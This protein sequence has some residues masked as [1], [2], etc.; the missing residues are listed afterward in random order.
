MKKKIVLIILSSIFFFCNTFAQKLIEFGEID[1]SKKDKPISVSNEDLKSDLI[2]IISGFP[3][4]GDKNKL[5]LKNGESEIKHVSKEGES[6]EQIVFKIPIA[7]LNQP[8]VANLKLPFIFNSKQIGSI[9]FN[10]KTQDQVNPVVVVQPAV[11]L[12]VAVVDVPVVVITPEPDLSTAYQKAFKDKTGK[13]FSSGKII[14]D[15]KLN[16]TRER[17]VIH[18][19]LDAEGTFYKSSLPTT[20][21]EDNI[22]IFHVFY[23]EGEKPILEYEGS[24]DPVFE[25]EGAESATNRAAKNAVG[26]NVKILEKTFGAVGPFTGSFTV[27]ITNSLTKKPI[28]NKT[29]KV[30][31]LHHITVNAGFYASFLRNP[32]NVETLVKPNG[33]TTLVADDPTSRGFINVM[34]TFYPFPRNIYF[35]SGDWRE[36]FAFNV[37]TT[38]SKNLSENIF[39]G[40]SYDVSRGL[41]LG[42]GAHYGRRS[43][44]ID[45]PD[46]KF[47]EDKF[48]GSLTARVKKRWDLGFYA[49][50]TIDMRLLGFLFNQPSASSTQ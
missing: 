37:G 16:Q 2:L 18:I 11:V 17:R 1:S 44:V 4:K 8:D 49:G 29:V 3:Q 34:L 7:V 26:T 25:V 13:D 21:R 31:K 10:K 5:V 36:K 6:K 50:V 35:P 20:A 45:Q 22:Y 27:K 14:F 43:Y 46:F 28:I 42:I 12:G 41:A 40:V 30:A 19:F 47:G 32:Q 38:I 9:I 15:E 48:S 39:G 23:K 24:Y 33:D